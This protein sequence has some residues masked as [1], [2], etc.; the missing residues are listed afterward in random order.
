MTYRYH[1]GEVV[2]LGDRVRYVGRPGFISHVIAPNSDDAIDFGLLRGAVI[3]SYGA[4]GM[5]SNVSFQPP[6][7]ANW[8]DLDFVARARG[9][10]TSDGAGGGTG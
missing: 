2:A 4:H 8:E 9:G 10:D 3:V 5:T 1:S 6:D 7:G